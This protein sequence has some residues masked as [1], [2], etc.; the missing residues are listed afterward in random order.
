[1]HNIEERAG[2][3]WFELNPSHCCFGL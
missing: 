3:E 2:P 1:M